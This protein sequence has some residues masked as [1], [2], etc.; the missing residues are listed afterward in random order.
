MIQSGLDIVT[1]LCIRRYNYQSND[2]YDYDL[3]ASEELRPLNRHQQTPV[4]QFDT[5]VSREKGIL[6]CMDNSAVPMGLSLVKELRCLGNQELVQVCHC[7]PDEMSEQ[8]KVRLLRADSRLEIVDVC[9]DL[10][11]RGV[12]THQVAETFRSGWLEPLALAYTDIA[13]VLLTDV[14]NVFFRDPAVLRST[15]G[16]KRTGTAFFYDRVFNQESNNLTHLKILLSEFG[17]ATFES[18]EGVELPDYVTR[19]YAY[20]DQT[21]R[22]QDSSLVAVNK[23]QSGKAMEL[24]SWFITE[25]RFEREFSFH[26]SESFWLAYALSKQEYIFSPWGPASSTHPGTKT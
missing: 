15:S 7:F 14:D 11:E 22:E 24:L 21:S 5:S 1:P 4:T 8:S 19:S 25:K 10:V 16:Y 6:M 20:K 9:S 26:E 17:Y 2:S 18:S 3:N 13:E 23:L 12:L